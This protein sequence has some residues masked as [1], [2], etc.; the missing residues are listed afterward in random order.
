MRKAK[1]LSLEELAP[2]T[3]N[4]PEPP[5]QI[6]WKA[7]FGNE[8]PVE[9]EI[10]FGKGW[11]LLNATQANPGINYF[12]VE[13]VRKY[14][15]FTATRLAKR[16][17]NNVKVAC[18]DAKKFVESGIPHGSLDKVH[19]FFPDPWWKSRH[20]KRKLFCPVFVQNLPSVVKPGGIIYIA[21]D[22]PEYFVDI[23][24][25]FQEKHPSLKAEEWGEGSPLSVVPEHLTNFEKKFVSQG[26]PIHR[27][28]YRKL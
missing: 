22:V 11:F 20:Q 17:L 7:T 12:G 3:A 5:D 23:T 25:L 10:G 8:N 2:V 21:T 14:Q 15:L 1:R 9:M 24:E 18:G 28:C 6:D 4:L 26:K 13:I 16:N 19:I 27:V